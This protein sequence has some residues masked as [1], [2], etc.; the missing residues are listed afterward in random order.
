MP[1]LPHGR[2]ITDSR[3]TLAHVMQWHKL[4]SRMLGWLTLGFAMHLVLTVL[5][6]GCGP[7]PSLTLATAHKCT[8]LSTLNSEGLNLGTGSGEPVYWRQCL[9]P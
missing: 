6:W 7:R 3:Q 1:A 4:N 8:S 5:F 9:F 2:Y